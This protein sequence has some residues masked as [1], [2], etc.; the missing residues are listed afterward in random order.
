[1][2][3]YLMSDVV[4]RAIHFDELVW[5]KLQKQADKYNTTPSKALDYILRNYYK[6]EQPTQ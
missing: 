2:R 5:L 6:L 4:K 1:M 3:N